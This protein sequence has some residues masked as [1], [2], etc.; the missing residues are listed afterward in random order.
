MK[1]TS[2]SINLVYGGVRLAANNELYHTYYKQKDPFSPGFY[3]T[4]RVKALIGDIIKA[5]IVKGWIKG[6]FRNTGKQ[7]A[8]RLVEDWQVKSG[9]AQIKFNSIRFNR[10]IHDRMNEFYSGEKSF[11]LRRN[12]LKYREFDRLRIQHSNPT[13]ANKTYSYIKC[14]KGLAHLHYD[15]REQKLR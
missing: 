8:S 7:F 14:E 10:T 11:G 9:S 15:H 5:R 4:Q 6:P 12:K 2:F 1:R 3:G 13:L